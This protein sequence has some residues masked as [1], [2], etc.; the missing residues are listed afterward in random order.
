MRLVGVGDVSL[1]VCWDGSGH[2]VFDFLGFWAIY[3]CVS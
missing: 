1:V 3:G 2:A